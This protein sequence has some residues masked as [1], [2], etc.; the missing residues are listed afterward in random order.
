MAGTLSA[1][2]GGAVYLH[3]GHDQVIPVHEV[4]AILDAGLLQQS[5]ETRQMFQRMWAVRQVRDLPEEARRAL[6]L[7]DHQLIVSPV[8][9]QTLMRRAHRPIAE[10]T[11]QTP[12][13]SL[14]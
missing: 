2:G 4:I 5:P 9:P 6:V 11:G 14:E 1:N 12:D 10:Q 3:I 13:D 7:T 8:M